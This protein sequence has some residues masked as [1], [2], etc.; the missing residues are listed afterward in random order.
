MAWRTAHAID[1][2]RNE[3]NR[4]W[5]NRSKVSDGTIGD[6]A[7]ASRTSDH[8]PWIKVNGVG[9]VR[10]IDITANGIDPDAYAE[11]L[12]ALGKAGD[13]R[14]TGGGYV[15]WNKRI[16]SEKQGWAWRRYT[17]AN[18]HTK[19]IHLSLS[20]KPAGFDS[21]A[22]WGILN[23]GRPKPPPPAPVDPNKGRPYRGFAA[24]TTDRA[25]YNAGGR[26]DQ[27]AE[28]EILFGLPVTGKYPTDGPLSDAVV[29]LKK[30][31]K[32]TDASGALDKSSRVDARFAQAVRN[33]VSGAD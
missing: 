14:L 19:H 17:G 7:H 25:I 29:A 9:V 16:A 2:L 30:I 32:W 20:T 11:H 21:R 1:E 23:L 13:P 10:A 3:V 22:S 8:N 18:G 15:I 5:P 28:L 6:A 24:P 27:V 26:N 12:R 31:A 33:L 4:R